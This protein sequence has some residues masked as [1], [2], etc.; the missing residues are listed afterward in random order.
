MSLKLDKRTAYELVTPVID[1]EASAEEKNA[2]FD[3]IADHPEVRLYYE[4]EQWLKKLV[5]EKADRHKTP[6][7][8]KRKI[9]NLIEK[10]AAEESGS[11][12]AE[13]WL[14]NKK[15]HEDSYLPSMTGNRSP[16][17]K[18]ISAYTIAAA[19]IFSTFIY[20]TLFNNREA[21]PVH[22][23]THELPSV[24]ENVHRHFVNNDGKLLRPDISPDSNIFAEA[25]V[26]EYS[27]TEFN[28]P[29][30]PDA[31]FEGIVDTEFLPDFHTP[32]LEYKAAEDDVIYIFAFNISDIRDRMKR[33]P[34]AVDQCRN[35]NDYYITTVGNADIVSWKWDDTW[36]AGISGLA[37]EKLA[38]LLPF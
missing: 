19:I 6:P 11:N 13:S 28:I 8:L 14:A 23:L 32:L 33:D 21:F 17:L 3:F 7:R 38:D 5:R 4:E 35:K 12:A 22:M 31:G 2:F 9:H 26:L 10:L 37:G 29:L 16:D 24:E 20:L 15:L 27:D 18:K 1:N 36:Y 30:L 25:M 34:R